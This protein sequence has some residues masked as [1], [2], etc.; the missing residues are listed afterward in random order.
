MAK[1]LLD[2]GAHLGETL[3]VALE[4][5]WGFDRICSFE[6]APQCWAALEEFDDPRVELYRFGLWSEDSSAPLYGS[7]EIGASL[8]AQKESGDGV[9]VIEL[10]KASTWFR[11]HLD[12]QDE[13]VMKVNCEGAEYDLLVD[14]INSGELSSVSFLVV[15]FDVL[16][17][18]GREHL[19]KELTRR[20][21]GADIAFLDAADIYFGRTTQEKTRN[22]LRWYHASSVGRLWWAYGRRLEFSARTAL[23]RVRTRRATHQ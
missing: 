11:D 7:G 12:P 20:L 14:L 6:P 8:F 16:K 9:S 4:P 21:R 2:I 3:S 19:A 10:R 13:I 5:M 15:H 22:F 23:Y 17:I 18:P 1:V